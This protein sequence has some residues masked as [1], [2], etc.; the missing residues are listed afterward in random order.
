[1]LQ[2]KRRF[3]YLFKVHV[4]K[5]AKW[6]S[7]KSRGRTLRFSI[8]SLLGDNFL[9]LALWV[10]FTSKNDYHYSIRAAVTNKTNGITKYFWI[11]VYCI[12]GDEVYSL[13]K[14]ISKEE[15]SITSGESI[16][17]SFERQLYSFDGERE[18]NYE[19]VKVEMCAAYVIQKTPITPDFPSVLNTLMN[20]D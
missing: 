10:L 5:I 12:A 1:M 19:Q 4:P 6:L 8:P 17:I 15:I 13:V 7:Y 20:F 2:V 18:V 9:G 14:C 3:L 11:P 16:D